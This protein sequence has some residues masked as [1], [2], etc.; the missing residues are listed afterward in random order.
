MEENGNI[1]SNIIRLVQKGKIQSADLLLRKDEELLNVRDNKGNTLVMIAINKIAQNNDESRKAIVYGMLAMLLTFRQDLNL[2]NY[3]NFTALSMAKLIN[4]QY[5]MYLLE[6]YDTKLNNGLLIAN[7]LESENENPDEFSDDDYADESETYFYD[8]P[9][10]MLENY[11]SNVKQSERINIGIKAA[12]L[13]LQKKIVK[14]GNKRK[15]K[16][17]PCKY[18]N[19]YF[20]K[21]S[22]TKK[23]ENYHCR[24]N[25]NKQS[26]TCKFCY[27]RIS[28]N[29]NLLRHQKTNCPY[30]F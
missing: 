28:N 29:S 4:D 7:E 16:K 11:S 22:A 2:T 13:S 27:K 8:N 21:Y 6:D 1:R 15:E 30:F 14:Q 23:H 12:K 3:R 18:C 17:K 25:P 26:V 19:H 20:Q 9:N 24:M 10:I 5:P